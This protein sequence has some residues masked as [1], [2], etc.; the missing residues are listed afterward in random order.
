MRPFRY[1]KSRR[2]SSITDSGKCTGTIR[3][4]PEVNEPVGPLR[5]EIGDGHEFDFLD[6]E[7]EIGPAPG[8][9]STSKK[10]PSANGFNL[11][12]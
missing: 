8:I 3:S 2:V 10:P 12:N 5:E 6:G 4:E 11:R 1:L 7:Y 9:L